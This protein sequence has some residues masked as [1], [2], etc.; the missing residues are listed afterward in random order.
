MLRWTA[1]NTFLEAAWDSNWLV[2]LASNTI[3]QSGWWH[4]ECS[5]PEEALPAWCKIHA[6]CML[7]NNATP[8]FCCGTGVQYSISVIIIYK[9]YIGRLWTVTMTH[10]YDY[11]LY[12]RYT[13]FT[14]QLLRNRYQY[15]AIW[16]LSRRFGEDS[17][18]NQEVLAFFALAPLFP[19]FAR[20]E[21][22][23][24]KS[25]GKVML[26]SLMKSK[27]WHLHSARLIEKNKAQRKRQIPC[28]KPP[29]TAFAKCALLSVARRLACFHAMLDSTPWTQQLLR[30]SH[31]KN[32]ETWYRISFQLS[33]WVCKAI[34]RIQSQVWGVCF[35]VL[36]ESV[37]GWQPLLQ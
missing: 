15:E 25:P 9:I 17:S 28:Q 34:N 7:V 21:S 4:Y 19:E 8:A 2:S 37:G 24:W 29:P 33:V 36:K 26:F 13:D 10:D 32:Q 11:A 5:W 31:R 12:C 1:T 20:S 6:Q 14:D 30:G 23:V 3:P 35:N 16:E 18:Q 27:I 22:S